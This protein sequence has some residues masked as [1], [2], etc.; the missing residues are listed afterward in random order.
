[1]VDA[2]L[3]LLEIEGGER[4]LLDRLLVRRESPRADRGRDGRD[5]ERT[6]QQIAP[7]ETCADHLAHGQVLGG[8]DPLVA[9]VFEIARTQADSMVS[10]YSFSR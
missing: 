4:G 3:D 7:V 8:V 10:L 9:R 1:M 5:C 6:P 2:G